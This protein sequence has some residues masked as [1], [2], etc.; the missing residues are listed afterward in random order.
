MVEFLI[1]FGCKLRLK[2]LVLGRLNVQIW[3]AL[4]FD[5]FVPVLLEYV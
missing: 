3:R 4:H 1:V 2:N 5:K